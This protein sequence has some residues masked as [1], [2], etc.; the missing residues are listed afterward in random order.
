MR[1]AKLDTIDLKILNSLM[2]NGRKSFRQ[3]SRETNISTPTVEARFERLRK[4]GII[5]N[6][7]PVIDLEK[8]ENIIL[9]IISIKTDPIES[10]TVAIKLASIS[11][12][13]NLYVA[14]GD[15]NLIA[16]TITRDQSHFEQI[17]QEILN[18]HG[19]ISMSY[20]VLKVIKDKI[21]IPIEKEV[22]ILIS[23]VMCNNHIHSFSYKVVDD[24]FSEKYF[25][26]KSC[27]KLY[28]QKNI[29]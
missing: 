5:K 22:N 16:K 19:I 29:K 10:N 9:S 15:Y 25:C 8:L 17:R 6:V 1:E 3:I 12:I 13:T 11:E 20:Q 26:C 24:S 21:N 23:C 28:K 27:I 4:V 2:Q 14:S 18:I 7:Q